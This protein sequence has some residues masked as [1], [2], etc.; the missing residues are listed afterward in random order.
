MA[1]AEEGFPVHRLIIMNENRNGGALQFWEKFATTSAPVV[2]CLR[3]Y[4][5]CCGFTCLQQHGCCTNWRLPPLSFELDGVG[6]FVNFFFFFFSDVV[7][8]LLC[9]RAISESVQPGHRVPT[10]PQDLLAH[11]PGTFLSRP[12]ARRFVGCSPPCEVSRPQARRG[13]ARP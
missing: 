3:L 8:E 4:I 10:H 9:R 1:N 12:C 7:M 6:A 2:K 5:H 13:R 11:K